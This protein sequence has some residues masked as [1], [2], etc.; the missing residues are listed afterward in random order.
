[1]KSKLVTNWPD[2]PIEWTW[3]SASNSKD[4][5]VISSIST[6]I[7]PNWV[8]FWFKVIVKTSS[9]SPSGIDPEQTKWKLSPTLKPL[10]GTDKLPT[11]EL[12]NKEPNTPPLI[13]VPKLVPAYWPP[14]GVNPLTLSTH[15]VLNRFNAEPKLP[16]PV[17]KGSSPL[18]KICLSWD[19]ISVIPTLKYKTLKG[20]PSSLI[21]KVLVPVRRWITFPVVV[22]K[23]PITPTPDRNKFSNCFVKLPRLPLDRE[24]LR[25]SPINSVLVLLTTFEILK[26]FSLKALISLPW[27]PTVLL[28]ACNVW[29]PP[30]PNPVILLLLRLIFPY[31]SILPSCSSVPD[32]SFCPNEL[33]TLKPWLIILPVHLRTLLNTVSVDGTEDTIFWI[34]SA[35]P[36]IVVFPS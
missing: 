20:L 22:V 14:T 19:R 6:A 13:I 30:N 16:T 28:K 34:S 31:N 12:G 4:A 36:V 11:P 35:I 21:E 9:L 33:V 1:M 3:K 18:A 5:L 23:E 15:R 8:P 27:I 24:L 25:I 7:W 17:V 10:A 32:I 26:V 2:T 29:V